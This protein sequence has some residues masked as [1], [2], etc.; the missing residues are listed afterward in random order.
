MIS[1][2]MFQ[3]NKLTF[4][5]FWM[6][7]NLIKMYVF[8][9][10]NYVSEWKWFDVMFVDEASASESAF[11]N[12]TIIVIW[13]QCLEWKSIWNMF[14]CA[15]EIDSRSTYFGVWPKWKI[16]TQPKMN[17]LACVSLNLTRSSVENR[18]PGWIS[19]SQLQINTDLSTVIDVFALILWPYN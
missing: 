2:E 13:T 17:T 19:V 5:S 14:Q 18:F 12:R 6:N 15:C 11:D 9:N 1:S 8:F 4:L 16:V 10:R 7:L 3:S